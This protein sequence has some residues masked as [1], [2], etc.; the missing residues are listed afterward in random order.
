MHCVVVKPAIRGVG[1]EEDNAIM[2]RVLGGKDRK[3]LSWMLNAPM[4][5]MGPLLRLDGEDHKMGARYDPAT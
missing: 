4:R 1:K 2:G 3:K 5:G